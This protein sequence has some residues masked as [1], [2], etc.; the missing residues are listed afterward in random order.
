[1]SADKVQIKDSA[2]PDTQPTLEQQYEKQKEAGLHKEEE[3]QEPQRPD[4]LPEKFKTPEEMAKAYSELEKKQAQPKP[5][6]KKPE[7]GGE[8]VG[9]KDGEKK[10]ETQSSVVEDASR[11]FFENG[12][13]SDETYDKLAKVG[14]TR[15][16]VDNY[17]NLQQKQGEALIEQAQAVAGGKEAYDEMA[18][19]AYNNLSKDE[20]QAYNKSMESE[21]SGQ[22]QLAVQGLKAKY[23]AAGNNPPKEL[24]KGKTSGSAGVEPFSSAAEV[25]RAMADPRYKESPAYRKEVEYR[26]S[27]SDVL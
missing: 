18:K 27:V 19:W 8:K 26:L 25:R 22:I 9:E 7:E 6:Q 21:D 13:L 4:W 12:G 5:D 14:L 3:Q 17:I 15:D 10:E 16:V 23:A 1:M 24:L 11:E 2:E 20:I